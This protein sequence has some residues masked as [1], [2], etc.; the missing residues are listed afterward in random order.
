MLLV[1][2]FLFYCDRPDVGVRVRGTDGMGF[3][4][5]ARCAVTA[6]VA[7]ASASDTSRG[8]PLCSVLGIMEVQPLSQSD[9]HDTET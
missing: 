5:F 6:A 1:H 3:E 4:T 7:L 8:C 2:F 9:D